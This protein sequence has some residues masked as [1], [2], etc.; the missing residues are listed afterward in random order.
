MFQN[1]CMSKSTQRTPPTEPSPDVQPLKVTREMHALI[2]KI[3]SLNGEATHV[4]MER[5][6]P[7]D[8]LRREL[9]RMLERELKGLGNRN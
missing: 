4:T 3:G 5:L 9:Q 7:L 1:A 8:G 6:L 2:M